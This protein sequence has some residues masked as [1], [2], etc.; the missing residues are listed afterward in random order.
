MVGG[1]AQ[2]TCR[3]FDDITHRVLAIT[4]LKR[5]LSG[6]AFARGALFGLHS[7]EA[8]TKK[9]SDRLHDQLEGLLDIIHEQSAA[10]W[11]APTS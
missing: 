3:D 1:L 6:H 4:Q 7:E 11:D 8:I 9:T 10:A 2:A 5:A